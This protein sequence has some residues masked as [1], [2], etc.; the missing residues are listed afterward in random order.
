MVRGPGLCISEDM[1]GKMP[2]LRSVLLHL[3]GQVH[4]HYINHETNPDQDQPGQLENKK[5][6]KRLSRSEEL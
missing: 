4:T 5:Q 2:M 3:A 1:F 6:K